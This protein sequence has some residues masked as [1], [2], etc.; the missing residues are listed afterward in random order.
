MTGLLLTLLY[1]TAMAAQEDDAEYIRGT[2][3]GEV[4]EWIV[5]RTPSHTSAVFS[6]L[7]PGVHS[8]SISGYTDDRFSREGSVSISFT[9]NDE[10]V[11]EP[12]V[13]YFPFNPLHPRF[14]FG[15]DHGTGELVIESIEIDTS[16]ARV[17]GR[18]QGELYYHQSPNTRPISRRTA[19]ADIEFNL[20]SVRQ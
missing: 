3:D 4:M 16:G 9:L 17:K 8:V 11:Q 13:L 7:L 20:L 10:R 1:T 6:T 12:E 15:S 19:E 14:S 5:H 18:Y 2:I